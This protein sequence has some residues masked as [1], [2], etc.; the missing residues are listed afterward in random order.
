[1][2]L[3]ERVLLRRGINFESARLVATEKIVEDLIRPRVTPFSI[4]SSHEE[5]ELCVYLNF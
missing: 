4:V 3:A 2:W 1:M 5:A